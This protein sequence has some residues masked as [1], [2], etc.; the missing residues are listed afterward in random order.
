MQP[1]REQTFDQ[2]GSH[3]KAPLPVRL[4]SKAWSNAVRL[5]RL[6]RQLA[7]PITE[8]NTAATTSS[9]LPGNEQ[10]PSL[11][12]DSV[13]LLGISSVYIDFQ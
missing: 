1:S 13:T 9:T 8:F 2:V 6:S 3:R 7:C 11:Y 5:R 12:L 10:G 4:K